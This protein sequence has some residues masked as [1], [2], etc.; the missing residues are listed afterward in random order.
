MGINSELYNKPAIRGDITGPVINTAGALTAI[1]EALELLA[2]G[3]PKN[4]E[5]AAKYIQKMAG[6]I[7]TIKETSQKLEAAFDR[8]SGWTPD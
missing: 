3:P 1:A 5:D 2:G 6:H 7:A 4:A 8:L